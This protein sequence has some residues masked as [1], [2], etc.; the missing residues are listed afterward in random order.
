MIYNDPK[1]GLTAS[2]IS[3]VYTK[4]FKIRYS[5]ID[6]HGVLKTVKIFDYFQDIASEHAAQMGI[7]G[8]DVLLKN[9][10]WVIYRYQLKI[11]KLPSWNET[12]EISTFRS[13][14]K[15]LYEYRFFKGMDAHGNLLFEGKTA[16]ILV[17]VE[18]RKPVR[19]DKHLPQLLTDDETILKNEYDFSELEALTRV[20][21]HAFFNVGLMDLDFN[22]HVN[23]SIYVQWAIE[24]VPEEILFSSGI[25]EIDI[26]FIAE[27]LYKDRITSQVQRM[28]GT[29]SPCFLHKIIREKDN[30]ELARLK[31]VWRKRSV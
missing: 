21:Q 28:E 16:W 26:K 14:Y 27:A 29:P 8:Y 4:T 7:S 9:L 25:T 10:A 2:A 13:P 31:S 5:D 24:A 17:D 1:T 6:L 15:K 30:M 22:K 12:I 18:K 20:D 19:L 23:N 3:G 11:D